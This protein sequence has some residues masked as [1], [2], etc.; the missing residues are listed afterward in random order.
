MAVVDTAFRCSSPDVACT[1]IVGDYFFTN[2]HRD[3]PIFGIL[4]I[5]M[6]RV[7]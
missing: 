4:C 1:A 2:M 3:K 7:W 6:F 5:T